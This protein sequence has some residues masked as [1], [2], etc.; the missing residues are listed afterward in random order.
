MK[1][2]NFEQAKAEYNSIMFDYCWEHCTIGTRFSEDTDGWNLRD[3]VSEA[4][5]H[6]DTCYEEGH[7][8]NEGRYPEYRKI[9]SS[10]ILSEEKYRRVIRHNEQEKELHEYWLRKTRRLRTFVRK[11]KKHIEQ[12]ECVSG[13]C[14]DFD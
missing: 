3:M 12:L 2:F 13:H 6:L 11:Y 5:Y 1:E 7:A 4:Q 8:E 9:D 10:C 14:S